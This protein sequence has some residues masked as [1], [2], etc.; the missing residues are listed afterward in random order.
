[1]VSM[2]ENPAPLI[3]ATQS[4]LITYPAPHSEYRLPDLQQLRPHF[5]IKN[6]NDHDQQILI[7]KSNVLMKTQT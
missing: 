5:A 2:E 7:P 1:V 3:S 6:V 4:G